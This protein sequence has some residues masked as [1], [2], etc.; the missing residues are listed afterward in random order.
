MEG[1]LGR[2]GDLR[3]EKGGPAYWLGWPLSVNL[4]SACAASEAIA[5]ARCVLPASC[6]TRE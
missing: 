6:V 5:P 1:S 4:A 3:L 2:F